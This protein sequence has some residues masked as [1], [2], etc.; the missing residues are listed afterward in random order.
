MKTS[1]CTRLR[2]ERSPA[3]YILKPLFEQSLRAACALLRSHYEPVRLASLH[4]HVEHLPQG[5]G[6]K[7][8]GN[9]VPIG[10]RDSQAVDGR[11]DRQVEQIEL[12]AAN[13]IDALY[14]RCIKPMLPRQVALV[15]RCKHVQ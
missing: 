11:P 3:G 7:L 14:M 9:H 8:P 2:P 15:F 1:A 10:D 5:S 12:V 13:R 6:G 4:L